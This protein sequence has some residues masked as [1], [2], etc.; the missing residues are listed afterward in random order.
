LNV[1]LRR[2]FQQVTFAVAD[3]TEGAPRSFAQ[4]VLELFEGLLDRVQ[5]DESI[6]LPPGSLSAVQNVRELAGLNADRLIER[7]SITIR[8]RRKRLLSHA[9]IRRECRPKAE[10]MALVVS[11]GGPLRR[12]RWPITGSMTVHPSRLVCASAER[13]TLLAGHEDALG[14]FGAVPALTPCR[15]SGRR[16]S[17]AHER[18]AGA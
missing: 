13:A 4:P 18:T 14:I 1:R 6:W 3:G 16:N 10:R 5:V 17:V 15:C 9:R 7:C 8:N 11:P 2:T 12:P